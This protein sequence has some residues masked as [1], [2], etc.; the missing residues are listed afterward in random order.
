MSTES[1]TP[2]RPLLLG[3]G[4]LARHLH[5]LL[6]L[7][8]IPH[9][10]HLDA[11]TLSDQSNGFDSGFLQ[12]ASLSTHVWLL[13]SDHALGSLSQIIQEK[14]PGI[15]ILHSSAAT[16]VPGAVTIHPLMTFGPDL[17]E[18]AIYDRIPLTLFREELEHAPSGGKIPIEGFLG[19]LPNPVRILRDH[20]RTRYHLSC[21]MF[22]NLSLLL[23]EAARRSAPASFSASDY[24][25]ILLQTALNFF[26]SGLSALTGPLARGDT[27]TIESHLR[28]L[29]A[30]PEQDLYEAFI[31]YFEIMN[32]ERPNADHR[33]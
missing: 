6:T 20:E 13:V 8:G 4:K 26:R 7:K 30:T 9:S 24:E 28:G 22:S 10:I 31:R 5:H 11:R 32:K 16:P 23:W 3:R 2:F 17:Y 15:A 18:V 19:R 21:V 14:L 29:K 25:P 1:N 12:K 33:A 27:P